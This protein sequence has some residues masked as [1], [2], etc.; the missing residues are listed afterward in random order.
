MVHTF[1]ENMAYIQRRLSELGLPIPPGSRFYEMLRVPEPSDGPATLKAVALARQATKDLLEMAFILRT[2]FAESPSDELREILRR[3]LRDA[4]LL[5]RSAKNPAGRNAQAELYA[6]AI[7]RCAG[8]RPEKTEPPDFRFTFEDEAWAVEVKR[9]QSP[10]RLEQRIREGFDALGDSG[11]TGLLFLDVSQ[12]LRNEPSHLGTHVPDEMIGLMWG[13][14]MERYVAEHSPPQWL[15]GLRRG[16]E[17][18]GLVIHDNFLLPQRVGWVLHSQMYGVCIDEQ[19]QRRQR[20][21][22]RVFAVIKT[23]TATANLME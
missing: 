14:R 7:L 4:T 20:Q 5:I 13:R 15:R 2:L 19:N 1:G 9:L 6:G 12:A 8:L 11:G 17:I 23:G 16:R 22:D 18:R 21:F 3:S 10:K